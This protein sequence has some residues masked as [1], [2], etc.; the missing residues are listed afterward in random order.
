MHDHD[1]HAY[2]QSAVYA[3]LNSD[4]QFK[5]F[6]SLLMVLSNNNL[7]ANELR[8]TN[9]HMVVIEWGLFKLGFNSRKF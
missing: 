8:V 5:T 4:S 7:R 9:I 6:E 2:R 1:L 3:K